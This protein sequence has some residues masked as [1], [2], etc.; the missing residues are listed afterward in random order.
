MLQN[1]QEED[2][3]RLIYWLDFGNTQNAGQVILGTF[4]ELLFPG[5]SHRKAGFVYQFHFGWHWRKTVVE[6]IPGRDDRQGGRVSEYGYDEDESGNGLTVFLIK[7][8]SN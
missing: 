8:G 2:H 7:R 6:A 4:G 5:R 1:R 3:K